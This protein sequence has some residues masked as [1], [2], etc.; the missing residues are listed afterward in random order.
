MNNS[1]L[2]EEIGEQTATAVKKWI[3]NNFIP[4]DEP[5]YKWSSYGLKH[6]LQNDAGIYL[7]NDQFKTAM[8]ECGFK[9]CNHEDKNW[10]FAISEKSPATQM[11][12]I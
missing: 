8:L 7:T 9:P 4:Q 6:T 10:I 1:K 3:R 11:R 2:C 12:M 5:N